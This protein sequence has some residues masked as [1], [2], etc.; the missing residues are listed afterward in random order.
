VRVVI[1]LVGISTGVVAL[2]L[3]A[4]AALAGTF[5]VLGLGIDVHI[6]NVYISSRVAAL[7]LSGFLICVG[8][9][10]FAIY[11]RARRKP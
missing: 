4:L 5:F 3:L 2:A 10:L 11:K 8:A 7:L 9:A 6:H 1:K